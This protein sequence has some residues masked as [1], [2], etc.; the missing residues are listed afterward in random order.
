M[1]TSKPTYGDG[2][3]P[4]NEKGYVVGM[5]GSYPKPGSI[6]IKDGETLTVE[7]RYKSGFLTGAMGHMY[8][9]LADRLA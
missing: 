4:G 7:T 6:K 2:K 8:I 9:Y 5:S 1:Y 3:E